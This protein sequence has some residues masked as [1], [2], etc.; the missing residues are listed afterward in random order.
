MSTKQLFSEIRYDRYSQAIRFYHEYRLVTQVHAGWANPVY[1]SSYFNILGAVDAIKHKIVG[2]FSINKD[3]ELEVRDDD[4]IGITGVLVVPSE[5]SM[6]VSSLLDYADDTRP[7]YP[8]EKSKTMIY[9]VDYA[10]IGVDITRDP[11]STT[12]DTLEIPKDH[13]I[14]ILASAKDAD[15]LGH[16]LNYCIDRTTLHIPNRCLPSFID[17]LSLIPSCDI[18]KR[19]RRN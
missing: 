17:E 5:V 7:R 4:T 13:I 12:R 1:A 9:S 15:A 19:Q 10:C 6:L 2:V 11:S 16:D 18:N 14:R 3:M 8:S